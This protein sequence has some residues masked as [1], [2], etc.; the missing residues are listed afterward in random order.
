MLSHCITKTYLY[1]FD[2]LKPLFYIVK[3][4]FTG[5]YIIFLT[6]AQNIDCGYSLEPP[7][8]GSSNECPQS[9]FSRNIKKT[10]EFLSEEFQFLVVKFS[11]YLN[12]RVFIMCHFKGTSVSFTYLT[13]FISSSSALERYVL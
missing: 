5:V 1:D 11:I 7:Q 6:S 12:R 9:V 3:Q 2:I 10:S 4:G 13:F 8:R